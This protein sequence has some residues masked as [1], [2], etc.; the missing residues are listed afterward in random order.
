MPIPE[1][2]PVDAWLLEKAAKE[3][4]SGRKVAVMLD[5][6]TR[7]LTFGLVEFAPD[8]DGLRLTLAGYRWLHDRRTEQTFL[9]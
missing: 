6:A 3:T 1:L 4:S 9:G 2:G 5:D 8:D 7:L